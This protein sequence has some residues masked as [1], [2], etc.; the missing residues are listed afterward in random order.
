MNIDFEIFEAGPVGQN[1]DRPHI[2]INKLG[3]FFLNRHA[4]AALGNPDA[5]T[6]MCDRRLQIIGMM[7]SDPRRTRSFPLR[8]KDGK[9][10]RGRVLHAMNFCKRYAIRPTETLAFL[11]PEIN[12]NGI[13]ILNLH[14]V[15]S[16]TTK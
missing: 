9:A 16:V 12:H 4:L 5:V 11:N 6:L 1:T 7:P 13:L 15:R 3:H 14:E 8:L 2:T 10:N